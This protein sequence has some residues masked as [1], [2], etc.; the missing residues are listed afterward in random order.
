MRMEVHIGRSRNIGILKIYA[1]SWKIQ[2]RASRPEE[3]TAGVTYL[4]MRIHPNISCIFPLK[5]VITL[6]SSSR[7]GAVRA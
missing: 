1:F 2:Q 6:L 5:V 3:R 4:F 7:K